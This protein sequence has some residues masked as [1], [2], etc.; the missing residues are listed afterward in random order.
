MEHFQKTIA[1]LGMGN[2]LFKDDGIGIH[3]VHTL[4]NES[5]PENVR[6]LDGGI[7]PCALFL[8]ANADKVIV[9]DAMRNGGEPGTIYCLK[10]EDLRQKQK[11]FSSTHGI[12][13]LDGL[14]IIKAVGKTKEIIIIGVEPKEIES[15]SE[16]SPE[17]A[18]KVPEI[19]KVIL[20]EVSE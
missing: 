18:K 9:V 19:V 3:V 20:K 10:L 16:L 15:G 11:S 2:A 12:S 5:C 14:Q 6:I 7:S 13:L 1:V 17:L 4:E 8:A